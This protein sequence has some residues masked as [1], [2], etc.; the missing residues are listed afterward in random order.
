MKMSDTIKRQA[1]VITELR[2]AL[3]DIRDYANSDKYAAPLATMNPAD[4]I[5]RIRDWTSRVNDIE[6]NG[7]AV[8]DDEP[9]VCELAEIS[10]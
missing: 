3:A 5:H 4:V 6:L 8:V 10:G 2:A 7:K 9:V 1:E